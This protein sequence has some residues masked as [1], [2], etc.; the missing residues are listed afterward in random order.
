M[1]GDS[2]N[3]DVHER[4]RLLVALSGPEEMS[5]A[6]RSWLAGHMEVCASCREFAETT[7]ET[8]RS[9]RASPITADG[10]LVA[11]T[12]ARVRQ[13][14]QELNRRQE[15]LW[16]ISICCAAVTIYTALSSAVLWWGLAWL[17]QQVRIASP[18]WEGGFIA[19]SFMPA[20]LA[21]ILLLAR[22]T[23]LAEHNGRYQ[24]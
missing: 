11:A 20:V 18:V 12:R 1:N 15:R 21:G 3:P 16:V 7:S 4:A 19:L 2:M 23:H 10:N 24:H 9:L 13:R 14:A 5:N 17:G 22:G 8:I 6:D